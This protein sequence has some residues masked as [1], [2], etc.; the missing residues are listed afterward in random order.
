MKWEEEPKSC[1]EKEVI[2]A[3]MK[4]SCSNLSTQLLNSPCCFL[5]C[6]TFWK[7]AD[8]L[9]DLPKARECATAGLWNE[10]YRYCFSGPFPDSLTGRLGLLWRQKKKKKNELQ[11]VRQ[12]Y[13]FYSPIVCDICPL[14]IYSVRWG[15]LRISL[16]RHQI[17]PGHQSSSWWEGC[18][19]L[20]VW[21]LKADELSLQPCL[22][23]SQLGQR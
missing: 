13:Y 2:I 15:T 5:G 7:G 19:S 3:L 17:R 9:D 14:G 18:Q 10:T 11:R 4:P 23:L 21:K 12:L 22:D 6:F 20:S 16:F 1:K 8:R